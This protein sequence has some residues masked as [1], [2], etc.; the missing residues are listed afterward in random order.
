[1]TYKAFYYVSGL[2]KYK[3][4]WHQSLLSH[5]KMYAEVRRVFFDI[6]GT[7]RVPETFEGSIDSA[8]GDASKT[9][10]ENNLQIFVRFLSEQAHSRSR[11]PLFRPCGLY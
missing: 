4:S 10:M 5:R 1:M 3:K 8:R 7:K 2:E 6:S 9:L 11:G